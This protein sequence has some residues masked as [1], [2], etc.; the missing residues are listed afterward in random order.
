MKILIIGNGGR[1]H[2]LAWKIKQEDQNIDLYCAKGNGGTEAL[3]K[4]IN[5]ENSDIQSLLNFADQEKIDFTIVGP[6]V[7]LSLGIVDLF[8]ANKHKIFGPNKKAALLESSKTFAKNLMKKYQIPTADF[9]AFNDY[10]SAKKYLANAKYPTVI[11]AD[12]LAAG[13]GVMIVNNLKEAEATLEKIFILKKFGSAG[14]KLVIEEFLTGVEASVLAFFDGFSFKI[15]PSAKDH[16]TIFDNDIGPNTGGMGA[17]SPSPKVNDTTIAYLEKNIFEPLLKAFR[18]ENIDYQG[19]VYAGLM[20]TDIGPKVIEFNAR[21]GDPETQVVLP[22]IKNNILE[23]MFLTADK[24][25]RDLKLEVIDKVALTVV[26]AAKGYPQ[27]YEKGII[28]KGLEQINNSFVFHAGTIFK[29]NQFLTNGGRVLNVTAIG[30][31]IQEARQKVY[32]DIAKI[33]FDGM[34]YR[35][36]IGNIASI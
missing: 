12:G 19:I 17:Y 33:H 5:I 6:E 3:A 22:R 29:D 32:Q 26:L 11:K 15:L 16:K 4:N 28:I 23:A 20:L 13:K 31:N 34:H 14:E 25:L 30:D 35:R 27:A 18:A 36:D 10:E 8:Q 24:K 9:A 7:P 2:C 21:F 1:E